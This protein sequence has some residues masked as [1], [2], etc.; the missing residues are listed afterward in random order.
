MYS[1]VEKSLLLLLSLS[2]SIFTGTKLLLTFFF[3]S[4]ILKKQYQNFKM[5][6]LYK[7]N[8]GET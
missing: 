3:N 7:L 8:K 1:F 6:Q 2:L 5:F 4:F